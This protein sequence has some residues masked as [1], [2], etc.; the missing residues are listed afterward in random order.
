MEHYLFSDLSVGVNRTNGFP[1]IFQ[2][3]AG[4]RC[5]PLLHT[6]DFYEI[7]LMLHGEAEQLINGRTCRLIYGQGC[8]LCPGASHRFLEQS[9]DAEV[10]ALSV[11]CTEFLR[12]AKAFALPELEKEAVLF[13]SAEPELDALL[14]RV[15]TC[16]TAASAERLFACRSL[17]AQCVFSFGNFQRKE[18]EDR[19]TR[20]LR[21][22]AK[23]ETLRAGMPAL[24]RLFGYSQA[25][26]I[27]IFRQKCGKTPHQ[28]LFALRMDYAYRLLAQNG[29]SVEQVCEACGFASLSH[30]CKAFTETFSV[31]PAVLRKS[32]R[33]V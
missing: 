20:L 11:E 1:Y 7:L 33:T 27:R 2:T 5:S 30:F 16:E 15:Q 29:L 10:L 26:L 9:P 8:V 13:F 6:H 17:F 28:V 4:R 24:R 21:E 19:F 3:T 23:P 12:F 22:V 32:F 25:Q 14:H 31:S 18:S